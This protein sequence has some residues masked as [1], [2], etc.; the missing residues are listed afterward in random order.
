M[1][2]SDRYRK[3]SL[4]VDAIFYFSL[5]ES[6]KAFVETLEFTPVDHVWFE[7]RTTHPLKRVAPLEFELHGV[8]PK[9]YSTVHWQEVDDF[10]AENDIWQATSVHGDDHKAIDDLVARG[11]TAKDI[12]QFAKTASGQSW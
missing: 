4:V 7:R 10:I 2:S 8:S 6:T 1:K 9:A 3:P 12:V 5:E 11:G